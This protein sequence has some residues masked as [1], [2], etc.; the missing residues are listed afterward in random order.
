[1]K[2]LS[3]LLKKA[4]NE[5][6]SNDTVNENMKILIGI[7]RGQLP[8]DWKITFSKLS[9]NDS[10]TQLTAIACSKKLESLLPAPKCKTES[11][12]ANFTIRNLT[13]VL[14]E[15]IEKRMTGRKT[16]LRKPVSLPA[17]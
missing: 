16:I 2:Q 3:D 9:D 5:I 14:A 17:L 4:K 7:F 6:D 8:N 13:K 11:N 15:D 10:A 1:M 12:S